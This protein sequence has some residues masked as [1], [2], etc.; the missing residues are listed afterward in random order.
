MAK[1]KAKKRAVKPKTR[2]KRVVKK[3]KSVARKD[4]AKA[5][6]RVNRELK[7]AKARLVKAEKQ[8]KGYAKKNPE[9]AI[10]DIL[11]LQKILIGNHDIACHT[12]DESVKSG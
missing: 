8:V 10:S 3:A 2:A 5:K 11:Y 4:V 7:A 9:K 1:K 6:A 12:V